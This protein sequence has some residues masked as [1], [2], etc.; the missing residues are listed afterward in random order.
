[1]SLTPTAVIADDEPLL[2]HHLNR[3]LAEVW[4]E[5]EIVASV[6]DGKS[7]LEVI[8]SHQPDVAFLDIRMPELDGMQV[9]SKL[10]RLDN[11]PHIVFITAY[12]EYAVKAFEQNAADY[13]LKP[14]SEDRLLKTCQKLQQKLTEQE[15]TANGDISQLLT[16]LQ[17]LQPQHA[18]EYLSWIKACRGEDVHLISVSEVLYFKAEDKYV[19]VFR[20]NAGKLEEFIIRLSLKELR[21][22]LNP[23]KFWQIHRSTVINVSAVDKV[24]KGLTGQMHV[25]IGNEKLPVSRS[26]QSLFKAL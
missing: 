15:K 9:A 8:E 10:N 22:Q 20:S 2:R 26:A 17:Q 12:D 1:M 14:L 16:Q 4:P 13:L 25:W 6:S 21:K 19:S 24:N 18:P 23:D 7:A 11:M 5:L 3:L